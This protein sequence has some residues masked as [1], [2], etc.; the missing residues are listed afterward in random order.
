M[1]DAKGTPR[2]SPWVPA[3]LQHALYPGNA[4]QQVREIL[5]I[6]DRERQADQHQTAVCRKPAL[7]SQYPGFFMGNGRL[8]FG[9]QAAALPGCNR[10]FHRITLVTALP[11][12]RYLPIR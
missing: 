9:K 2:L 7:C 11:G 10:H 3:G 5:Q 4:R 1:C 8:K 12:H 6:G